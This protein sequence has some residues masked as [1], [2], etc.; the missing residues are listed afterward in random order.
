MKIPTKF[1]DSNLPPLQSFRHRRRLP[2]RAQRPDFCAHAPLLNRTVLPIRHF[3]ELHI[4]QSGLK[5]KKKLYIRTG[6]TYCGYLE[7]KKGDQESKTKSVILKRCKAK[8][9]VNKDYFKTWGFF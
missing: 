8:Q 9:V 5:K 4:L 2:T 3:H 6:S 1:F 7:K